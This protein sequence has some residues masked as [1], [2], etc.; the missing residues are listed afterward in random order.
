M[1]HQCFSSGEAA[2]IIPPAGFGASAGQSNESST[3]DN[4]EPDAIAESGGEAGGKRGHGTSEMNQAGCTSDAMPMAGTLAACRWACQ[5]SI[6]QPISPTICKARRPGGM[7]VVH[8][9]FHQENSD[10]GSPQPTS[11]KKS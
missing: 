4:G 8:G 7:R 10:S 2:A 11:H 5:R 3:G 9:P 6:P 1:I